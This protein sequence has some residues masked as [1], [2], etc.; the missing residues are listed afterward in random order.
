MNKFYIERLLSEIDKISIRVE[1]LSKIVY[2]NSAVM[3]MVVKLLIGIATVIIISYGA[4]LYN[5]M[6][7]NKIK[8]I[9]YEIS[10]NLQDKKTSPDFVYQIKKRSRKYYETKK[11]IQ[12][13]GK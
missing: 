6:I 12:N 9:D 11:G 7:S 4:V 13:L 8:V 3:N 2:T 5:N 10:R 1:S